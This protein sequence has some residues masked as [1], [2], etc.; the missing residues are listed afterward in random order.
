MRSQ[1]ESSSKLLRSLLLFLLFLLLCLALPIS[2]KAQQIGPGGSL[3]TDTKASTVGDLLTVII[4]EDAQ[5]S[6]QTTLKTEEKTDFATSGGPGL[7]PL[8]F[9]PLFGAKGQSGHT[10]DGKGTNSRKGNIKARMTVEVIAERPNGDLVL[11]GNRVLVIN[12]EQEVITLQGI[13][14]RAD[15]NPDNTI[16]S[17]NIANAKIDYSGKGPSS[18]GSKPGLVS[19]LLNWIF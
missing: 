17:Y 4:F 16:Y 6:N 12:S 9:I 18:E 8:D 13:V 2:L 19:R 14:R 11:V 1:S 10:Y 3:F 5:A 15:I 7:G